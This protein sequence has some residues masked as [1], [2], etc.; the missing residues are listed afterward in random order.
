MRERE[1]ADALDAVRNAINGRVLADRERAKRFQ[2]R[3]EKN[4][5]DAFKERMRRID[6]K[7]GKTRTLGERGA[8]DPVK[9]CR[10]KDFGQTDA[11]EK[12]LVFDVFKAC[13]QANFDEPFNVGERFA[14]DSLDAVRNAINGRVFIG[15]IEEERFRFR[16][17]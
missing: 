15:G 6:V 8:V 11:T 2:P 10:E 1:E 17:E 12:G 14:A 16:V 4:A 13:R 9:V 7:L 5:V 3:V